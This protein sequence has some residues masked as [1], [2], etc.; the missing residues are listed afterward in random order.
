MYDVIGYGVELVFAVADGHTANGKHRLHD[1]L[2]EQVVATFGHV[3]CSPVE[4]GEDDE[5]VRYV[6]VLDPGDKPNPGHFG[7]LV[8]RFGPFKVEVTRNV[9]IV[10]DSFE[11]AV[12][13]PAVQ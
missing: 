7:G 9:W 12:G 11:F 13:S 6:F 1:A 2:V 8:E 4:V 10:G 3:G 5:A